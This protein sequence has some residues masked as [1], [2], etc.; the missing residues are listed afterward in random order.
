MRCLHR[1]TQDGDASFRCGLCFQSAYPL[2]KLFDR[3]G[4]ISKVVHL[5]QRYYHQYH[6]ASYHHKCRDSESKIPYYA[7]LW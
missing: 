4:R 5:S 7:R 6:K 1:F 3:F 2:F